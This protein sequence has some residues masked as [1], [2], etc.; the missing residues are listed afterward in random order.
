MPVR[1]GI[2]VGGTFTDVVVQD[3]ATGE[4]RF[5]K[6]DSTPKDQSIGILNG[7]RSA[8]K[9]YGIDFMETA[10]LIHGTT[11]ATNAVL[12]HEGGQ[13]VLFTTDGFG[14]ILEVAR[15][16]RPKLYDSWARKPEA[17]IPRQHIFEVPERITYDGEVLRELDR[18]AVAAQLDKLSRATQ[19]D[20]IVISFLHSYKNPLHEQIVRDL[21]QSRFPDIP[22]F[23]SHEVH[24]LIREFERTSTVVI[25]AYITPK[26]RWYLRR[27]ASG[28]KE[29]EFQ[30]DFYVMQANGGMISTGTAE[31]KGMYTI[32]SGPA[33]GVLGAGR[34]GKLAGFPNVITLDMGG[35]S[36]DVALIKDGEKEIVSSTEI[37][38]HPLSVSTININA[39]GAGG[40]SIAWI[41]HG[42]TL[43][44]GPKSAG[45]DPGP[46][47]YDRGG[48]E[49]TVTDANLVIGV[50]D[51]D[52]FLGG[53][54]S[55]DRQK[56]YEAI[57]T[58]L[59]EP[60]GMGVEEVANG[61]IR[62]ANACMVRAIRVISVEGGHDP[63][64]FALVAFG[65]A[66]PMHAAAVAK[67]LNIP[68]VI[69]PFAPGILSAYGCLVAD[70]QM[71][72][73]RTYI[74]SLSDLDLETANQLFAD[75][76]T[77]G[78]DLMKKERVRPENIS[79]MRSA[80]MKYAGQAYELSVPLPEGDIDQKMVE[81]LAERFHEIHEKAYGYAIKSEPIEVVN[82]RLTAVGR[83]AQKSMV[84]KAVQ[85]ARTGGLETVRRQR[86]VFFADTWQQ[87]SVFTREDLCAGDEFPGPAIIEG[88]DST[89]VVAPGQR[90][91][92]D[93]YN[94]IIID[95]R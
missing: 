46:V 45:A 12:E 68:K 15:Q 65:G 19:P 81:L 94:N 69:A 22:V 57:R 24:P 64:E 32:L 43:R 62:V 78:R 70:V 39:V 50:I 47:A 61:I 92:V 26:I 77:E 41:D 73:A 3:E 54:K 30:K 79:L 90:A 35:T 93:D 18:E 55:L 44:V 75:M 82:L 83:L 60:L 87:T 29:M 58:K 53:E 52:N 72:Y 21:A 9:K 8:L 37:G 89:V 36:A 40:G 80:D 4:V 17:L 31:T 34:V 14:D 33:A 74:K 16:I 76:E 11:V 49:P 56:A 67:E 28:L 48:R 2:D 6:V 84:Q 13:T 88:R 95:V 25:N 7:I 20:A 86:E 51:P 1:F 66:G 10:Q 42:G 85:G 91:L 27:L 5:V 71:D 38:G 59:A 23:T 63:R